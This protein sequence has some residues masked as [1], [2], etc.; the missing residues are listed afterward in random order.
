MISIIL[1][2]YKRIKSLDRAI[3]A[4]ISQNFQDFE[5]IIVCFINEKKKVHNLI[6]KY[7]FKIFLV[8]ETNKKSQIAA[9]NKGLEFTKG[10]IVCFIDDDVVPFKDW[11]QKIN[12][13]FKDS[14]NKNIGGIGGRDILYDNNKNINI[15]AKKVGKIT[16]FGKI[17]GNHHCIAK[18]QYVDTLKG[19][20][21]CFRKEAI[22][23][24]T[25]NKNFIGGGAE[26]RN[27]TDFCLQVKKRGW[28]LLYI[29][30]LSVKHYHEKRHEDNIRGVFNK[31][32]VYN[33]AFNETVMLKKYLSSFRFLLYIIRSFLIGDKFLSGLVYF[34]YLLPKERKNSFLRL[35]YSIK[36]RVRG[37]FS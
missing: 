37:L 27:D 16:Y 33:A 8:I 6:K 28:K 17:I 2:T 24:L 35:F 25:F 20:N 23:G 32:A 13:F 4:L 7:N 9:L 5:L 21:M 12:D 29:D 36:G 22:Q 3:Q 26:Y 34:L 31:K 1:P 10:E 30:T 11:L 18:T 15:I 14:T 19:A